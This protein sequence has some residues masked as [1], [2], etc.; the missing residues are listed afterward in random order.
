MPVTGTRSRPFPGSGLVRALPLLAVV[1]CAALVFRGSLAYFFSAD[2]FA[3]LARARGL[4]PSYPGLWRWLSGTAYFALMRPFGLDAAAYHAVNLAAHA[5]C[6][7]ILFALLRRRFSGPASLLGALFFGTHAA[8]YTAVYWVSTLN[9]IL[10][11]LFALLCIACAARP[12]R[13]AWLSVPLFALS[14][15]SKETTL[16]LPAALWISPG[17]LDARDRPPASEDAARRWRLPV[18]I[19]LSA[20]ALIYLATWIWTDVSG[21]R[22][23]P[24]ASAPYAVGFG[25][26]VLANATS[27][28]GWTVGMLLPATRRFD[29]VADPGLW[30]WAVAAF[31]L[32]LSGVFSARLRANGWIAGGATFA[33]LLVPVLGLRNHTYH[34][35]LYAP[36]IGAAWCVAALADA[37]FRSPVARTENAGRARSGTSASPGEALAWP[38]ASF[39]GMAFLLN[40]AF[41]VHK[42]ENMPFMDGR[43]R[44]DSTVDRARIARRVYDGLAA[45]EL[46]A[47]ARLLFWSPASMRYERLLHPQ[48]DVIGRETYWER[49]VRA[50]LQDGLGVRVMFPQ[51]DSV[52]FLHAYRPAEADRRFVLYDIDGMVRVE[53]PAR[54]DSVLRQAAV[55]P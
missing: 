35:Y 28:L 40:G 26:H 18:R 30:P 1:A 38:I 37:W 3:A 6:V 5:A 14:L 41:L 4:A 42:I 34:Y 53:T 29:D 24:E 36:L 27:Y 49:N 47:G 39:V 45:A 2:D 17:W 55:A 9:E 31:A 21:T 11:L 8:L 23:H 25:P 43:L 48:A 50:A 16:L 54:V 12:G 22:A 10:A 20:V 19:A 44:A 33:L 13:S 7:G 46:P 51:V 32:W 52:E 15:I